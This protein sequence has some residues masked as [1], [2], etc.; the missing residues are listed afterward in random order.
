MSIQPSDELT[1]SPLA[2]R[3]IAVTRTAPSNYDLTTVLTTLGAD[4]TAYPCVEV[5]PAPDEPAYVRALR[6]QARAKTGWLLFP[7]LDSVVATEV[8]LAALPRRLSIPAEVQVAAF[9]NLAHASAAELLRRA[10]DT[11]GVIDE[12]DALIAAMQL[13]TGST[14]LIPHAAGARTDWPALVT[15]AGATAHPVAAYRAVMPLESSPLPFMLWSGAVDAITFLTESDVRYFVARIK[16]DGGTP[17]MLDDV[18]VACLDRACLNIAQTFGIKVS[19]LPPVPTLDALVNALAS[20][21]A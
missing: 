7:T 11:P 3:S 20:A 5:Q 17:A 9:G 15:R 19:V 2:G 8:A 4:V 21:F 14:V 1:G 18:I 12:H 13:Q 10:P 16:H 6:A